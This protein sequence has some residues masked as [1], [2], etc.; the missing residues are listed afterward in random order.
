MVPRRALRPHPGVEVSLAFSL[1][2]VPHGVRFGIRAI[3]AVPTHVSRFNPGE[4]ESACASY[5]AISPCV[6]I[7][8]AR[9]H[10]LPD[11]P[12]PC[13][14]PSSLA[15]FRLRSCGPAVFPPSSLP[16][17]CYVCRSSAGSSRFLP[18]GH[19]AASI[20]LFGTHCLRR[21][22]LPTFGISRNPGNV[23]IFS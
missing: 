12:R 3:P 2:P 21:E 7:R 9:R 19:P 23:L 1:D 22:L 15:G 4:R 16:A 17:H 5:P 11:L 20:R 18:N 13:R 8:L 6:S 14:S 10:F